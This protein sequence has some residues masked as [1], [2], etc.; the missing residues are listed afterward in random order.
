MKRLKF[1]LM[2]LMA[3]VMTAVLDSCDRFGWNNP[4]C[5]AVDSVYVAEY[6]DSAM[7]PLFASPEEIMQY[8]AASIDEA[9]VDETFRQMPV[10]VLL[11]VST[12]C[13][14]KDAVTSKKDIVEEYLANRAIYDNLPP[15]SN[16]S[17][18]SQSDQ[19][20]STNDVSAKEE[21]SRPAEKYTLYKVDTVNGSKVELYIK[22]KDDE[23]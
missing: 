20:G 18:T 3:C 13:L 19:H 14:K 8:Q 9:S 11:N 4:P 22:Q 12:V 2:A 7:D 17:T 5:N 15:D 10:D 1:V 23:K 21:H 16:S 6:V